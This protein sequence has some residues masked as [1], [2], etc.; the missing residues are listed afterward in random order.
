M[1]LSPFVYWGQTGS[2]LTLRIDLK[3][4]INPIIELTERRLAFSGEGYGARGQNQYMFSIDFYDEIDPS[5]SFYR[6]IDR[7]IEFVV[8]KKITSDWPQLLESGQKAAA[9]LKVDFEKMID[10]ESDS[11]TTNQNEVIDWR[12]TPNLMRNLKHKYCCL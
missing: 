10:E 12:R 9:W 8:K 11:E 3:R 4:T 2:V 7:D 5:D 6:V 1:S